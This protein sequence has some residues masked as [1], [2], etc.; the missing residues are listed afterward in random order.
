MSLR[1]GEPRGR[2]ELLLW[3]NSLCNAEYPA[4]ESLRDGAAYCTVIEAAVRRAAQNCVA[5]D[6]REAPSLEE[7]AKRAGMLLFKLDW[8]ATPAVCENVDSSL[9][10]MGVHE[11][12]KKNM[13]VL[14]DMLRT[15][16]PPSY[17][18]EIDINR[19]ASGKLQ[20]HVLLLRW[21]YRFV[22][23]VLADYSKKTLERKSYESARELTGVK[24]NR[25]SRLREQMSAGD[26]GSRISPR[27]GK[28]DEARRHQHAQPL[29]SD[30]GVPRSSSDAR[31]S[32]DREE[33]VS[34]GPGRT[35][36]SSLQAAEIPQAASSRS[37]AAV[38]AS[39]AAR[40]AAQPELTA[41]EYYSGGTVTVPK[42]LKDLILDLRRDV[43]AVEGL[44]LMANEQHQ[45]CLTE[46]NSL[47][48]CPVGEATRALVESTAA[49][50]P[51]ESSTV[52]LQK[53]GALLEER[54][55]LARTVGDAVAVL[56][57]FQED[58]ACR[59]QLSTDLHD[60]LLAGGSRV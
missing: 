50:S 53:L 6:L 15:S 7:Q 40:T 60:I 12:C 39:A 14:Q 18:R 11:T 56:Q 49:L 41:L 16:V 52:S 57:R 1:Q 20:D 9:D 5:L 17:K 27:Q 38:P 43:E 21:L 44:V 28:P 48:P 35:S 55:A 2:S 31:T 36:S 47:P 54:D 29:A 42:T 37:P 13:E 58:S 4:V 10:S 51:I 33:G 26:S 23:K 34:Q 45:K 22:S 59:C 46:D 25:T 8:T 19:L 24:L 3:L 30:G 32:R